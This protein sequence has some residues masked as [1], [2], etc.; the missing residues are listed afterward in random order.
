[1]DRLLNRQVDQIVA[2]T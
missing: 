1:M 2:R